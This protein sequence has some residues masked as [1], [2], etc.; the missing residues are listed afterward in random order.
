M[1]RGGTLIVMK[2]FLSISVLLQTVTGLMTLV[3]VTMFALYAMEALQSREQARR[4]PIIVD[5]SSD[6]FTA[7]QTF[8]VERGAVNT[9]LRTAAVIDPDAQRAIAKW[10]GE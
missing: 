10:R 8:R 3:L 1:P 6:L 9:G 5:I 7:I 2:R 4:I